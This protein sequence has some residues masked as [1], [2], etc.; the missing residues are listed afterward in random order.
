MARH[1]PMHLP[2]NRLALIAI[3]LLL[4]VAGARAYTPL[5]EVGTSGTSPDPFYGEAPY[6]SLPVGKTLVVPVVVSGSGPISYS[7]T[8]SSPAIVP[9]VKTGYPVMNIHVTY[10][11]V[12]GSFSTLYVF[13]DG[14]ANG[15]GPTAGVTET[16]DGTL[17][18]TTGTGGP[19]NYGTVYELTTSGSLFT[20]H[21]FTG[22]ADGGTPGA[23]VLSV[24]GTAFYGTTVVGGTSGGYGTAYMVDTTGSLT[25]LHSFDGVNDGANPYGGLISGTDNNLYGTT[26]NKGTT[27]SSGA[28]SGTVFKMSLTG[29]LTTL[30]TFTGQDD[31]GEPSGTLATG[32]DGEFYGTTMVGGTGNYGTVFKITSSGT[33]TTLH[34]FG[35]ATDGSTP[36]AGLFLGTGNNFYGVAELGGTA[37]YGTVYEVTGSGS[38]NVIHT[39]TGG[40]DGGMPIGG[41]IQATDGNL[42]GTTSMGG[43]NGYGTIFQ[44]SP[45][46]S[47]FTVVH[48]FTGGGDG[49]KPY[50]G[51]IQG[52]NGDI[53]GTTT[54]G[55]NN[56]G[57]VFSQPPPMEGAF[58]GSMTFAL[59]RDMAPVTTGYIAGFAQGGYYDNLDFFRIV[60]LSGTASG[61]PSDYIAQGGDPSETGTGSVGFAFDNE[62]NPSLIYT[63]HGQLGMAN[64][65]FDPNGTFHGTNGAQFFITQSPRTGPSDQAAL[66]SL[67]FVNPIFGQMLEG[68]DVLAKVMAVPVVSPTSGMPQSP[69]VMDSVTVSED[70]ND[71]IL[72]LSGAAADANGATITVR[73]TDKDGNK[74]GVIST[75]GTAITPELQIHTS[76]FDDSVNDPP[77]IEPEPTVYAALH[78]SVSLPIKA[79]D[80]EFD[81]LQPNATSISDNSFASVNLSGN[82]VS[83]TPNA[84]EPMAGVTVGLSV[85]QPLTSDSRGTP[86]ETPVTV[87]LGLG[88]FTPLPALFT[89]APTNPLNSSTGAVMDNALTFGSFVTSNPAETPG[90]FTASI[91]WGDGTELT[92]GTN[93][94]S[95]EQSQ[96]LPTEY[97]VD[98]PGGVGNHNYKGA[99]VYPINV[100]VTGSSGELVQLSNTAAVFPGPIYPFGRTFT[101]AKGVYKGVVCAF[102]D[103]TFNT[104]VADYTA[105]IN[106]G[107]GTVSAGNGIVRGANGNFQVYGEHTYK[108]GNSYPVDVTVH[109]TD[110]SGPDAYAWSIAKVTGVPTK[111]PPFAQSHIVAQLANPGY[112]SGFFD[113]QV[114]LIN[115]GN[116]A[117]GPVV[118]KFYLG[119]TAGTDSTS[120]ASDLPLRIGSGNSYTTV[121]IPGGG[122]IEG[123]V[124]DII[125]PSGTT[126]RGHYLIMQVITSDP[127]GSHMDYPRVFADPNQLI[128]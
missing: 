89:A 108:S 105:T 45:G 103:R 62:F 63:G 12:T 13:T 91:N 123:S 38:T 16:A 98:L 115:T 4:T 20:L 70:D 8:S 10:A 102:V 99:G 22:G 33:L 66:R 60:N 97:D 24:G 118:L 9:I 117:S 19:A 25:T 55:T 96:R 67:D 84:A 21:A 79:R 31:G 106:W 116:I 54:T 34:S 27:A 94:V 26:Q 32:T 39:F 127:I 64:E 18:G 5:F 80:L 93:K 121:P 15:G 109:S 82:V 69:V 113:E 95:I 100:T 111:Q 41:L 68:F 128:E 23:G 74:V 65:G 110:N 46:G 14:T 72:L 59:L 36:V 124:S 75:S 107:D 61:E 11:G 119:T 1:F 3:A 51:L 37:G 56:Q 125:I 122:A 92:T 73:A 48:A 101:A 78:Q 47:P 71:A 44:V 2:P 104:A 30:Y 76:T 126:T 43:T 29:S 88:K 6:T 120:L 112:G 57:T 58:S 86:D 49:G 114:T 53:Y 90:N 85:T 83:I 28:G 17:F 50:G 40:N 7:V 81:Y 42:Y 77:I 35:G 52:S 87:D